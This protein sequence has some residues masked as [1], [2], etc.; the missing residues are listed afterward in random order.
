MALSCKERRALL[1][2]SL[3]A[4]QQVQQAVRDYMARTG[5][6]LADFAQR[7]GYARSSL[8][9]FLRDRYQVVAGNDHAIIRAASSYIEAHPIEPE[10]ATDGTLHETGNVKLIRRLFGQCLRYGYAAVIEG[11]PGSQKTFVVQHLI[12]ELNRREISKN[13]SGM[14][15]YRVRCGRISVAELMKRIAMAMGVA[16]DGGRERILRN[17]RHEFARRRA[18]LVFD[19][20]QQLSVDCLEFIRE[21]L[22][23]PPC[24]GMLLLGS[25]KLRRFFITHRA[26]MEQWDS[27]LVA[28]VE[29]PG[30]TEKEA[31]DIIARELPSTASSAAT[32]MVRDCYT[33]ALGSEGKRHYISAR[34]LFRLVEGLKARAHHSVTAVTAAGAVSA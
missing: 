1:A 5:L 22:D 32:K 31:L 27:R 28:N 15:A 18:I 8:N 9:S 14:R 33:D 25:D 23:E 24:F 7:I 29:L 12:A 19:E 3:P 4:R 26:D 21:L 11:P 6:T 17:V 10:T 13:G 34:R 20:A 2:R 16:S 30:V